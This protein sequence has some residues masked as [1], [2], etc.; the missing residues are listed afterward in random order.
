MEALGDGLRQRRIRDSLWVRSCLWRETIHGDGTK[1]GD[2]VVVNQP[3]RSRAGWV[4]LTESR[5]ID[6]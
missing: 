3:R 6:Q 1:V 2:E 5:V 4:S